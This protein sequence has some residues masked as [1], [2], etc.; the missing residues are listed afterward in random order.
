MDIKKLGKLGMGTWYMGEDPSKYK[1]EYE[2]LSYGLDEGI[3]I[4]DTAEMYGSGLSEKLVGDVIKNYDR[5][6]IY[7]ISKFF[8]QNASKEKIEKALDKSLKRLNTD[9]LDLYLY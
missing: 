1:S 9:Y 8:P 2:S 6:K 4:I 7:L 5:D 3:N